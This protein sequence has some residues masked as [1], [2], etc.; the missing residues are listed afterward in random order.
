MGRAN[1]YDVATSTFCAY[2]KSS[3]STW[4][5]YSSVF[6]GQIKF[7]PKKVHSNLCLNT[8][9]M[10]NEGIDANSPV[11]QLT[12]L[13]FTLKTQLESATS[14]ADMAFKVCLKLSLHTSLSP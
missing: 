9:R 11:V 8:L 2:S 10:E 14:A 12:N 1:I 13:R 6:K 7:R 3:Y 4:T 5:P